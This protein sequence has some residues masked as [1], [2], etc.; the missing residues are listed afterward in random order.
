[1]RGVLAIG[2]VSAPMPCWAAPADEMAG[3]V[4]L[5]GRN[6]KTSTRIEEIWR[7]GP[8]GVPIQINL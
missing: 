2:V 3:K 4:A 1:M 6:A 8:N 5:N 7:L